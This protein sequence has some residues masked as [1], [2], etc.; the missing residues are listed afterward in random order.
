MTDRM[1]HRAGREGASGAVSRP[2]RLPEA[3]RWFV[4]LDVDGTIMHEDESI[5][6]RVADAVALFTPSGAMSS[7][8]VQ[9]IA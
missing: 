7:Q 1:P 6:P 2:E 4:A 8:A 5:D 9:P 3:D